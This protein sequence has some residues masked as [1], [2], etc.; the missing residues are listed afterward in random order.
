ML[1]VLSVLLAACQGEEPETPRPSAAAVEEPSPE[2]PPPPPPPICPLTGLEAGGADLNRPALGVKIDNHPRSRPQAGLESADIVY[3][4]LVEGGLTRFLAMFHCGNAGSVGP[5]RS[6][7]LVDPDLLVQHQPALFGYSG[8]APQILNKVRSAA[9]IIDLAHGA[10]GGAY[11]RRRGRPAP[12]NLYTSS[13]VLRGTP[14]AQGV[15]GQPK[16]GLIFDASSAGPPGGPGGIV[17]FAYSGGN[18]VSYTF[19]PAT[20]KYLR[21]INGAAHR[22]E[23]QNQLATSNVVVMKVGVQV[24]GGG[25][26][27]AVTGEGEM[28]VLRNGQA[29]G[30]K[31]IRPAPGDQTTLVDPA[32]QPIKLLPGNTWIHLVPNTQPIMIQ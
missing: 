15:Q 25:V 7:R 31:W 24:I 10:N 28:T 18:G 32:G 26:H 6:A 16:T 17:S 27:I 13:D 30:G 19:D 4:Q 11:S 14:A 3:E 2:P 20:Q 29:F 22:D 23:N 12:Y 21:A 5:V 1:L 8:A 9:G